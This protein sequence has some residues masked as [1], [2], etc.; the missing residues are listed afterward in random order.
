MWSQEGTG[1]VA[2]TIPQVTLFAQSEGH[3]TKTVFL[4]LKPATSNL[5]TYLTE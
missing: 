4:F 5:F 1:S 3:Y 2:C